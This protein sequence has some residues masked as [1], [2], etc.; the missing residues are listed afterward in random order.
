[1]LL[2]IEWQVVVSRHGMAFRK[3]GVSF[4]NV[5]PVFNSRYNLLCYTEGA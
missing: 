1:V 3:Y 4:R 5:Q 2:R